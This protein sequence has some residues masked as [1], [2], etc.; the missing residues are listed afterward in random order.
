ML[1]YQ[2]AN[3]LT[4]PATKLSS[5][6]G[7][8]LKTLELYKNKG[9]LDDIVLGVS[10][11]GN[12]VVK[13]SPFK[14]SGITQPTKARSL[15]VFDRQIQERGGIKQAVDYF[16]EGVSIKDLQKFNREMGYKTPVK[17]IAA[18][19]S[20]VKQATGQDQKIPR[21]FIF[22]KKIGAY[23]LNLTGNSKYTTIDVWESRFI[24][25]YFNG[26]FEKNTGLPATVDEDTL[27][28]D[29]SRVF[30]E[31]FDKIAGYDVDPS[32]LQA[33]R[34]F[35]MINAAK[36]A[37]YR[38]ASTNETISEL[39]A[40]KIGA[41]RAGGQA[42]RRAG[43][44]TSAQ[45]RTGAIPEISQD[46]I[47]LSL[48]RLDGVPESF[49]VDGQAVEF[50]YFEPAVEAAK[51]YTA[52]RGMNY[53]PLTEYAPV[54][55]DVARR[56]AAEFELMRHAPDDPEV[57]ASYNAMINETK[58]QYRDILDTGLEVQFIKDED[59]YGN[60]RNAILDVVN[61][62]HL[63]VFPTVDG[64]GSNA[65][66]DVS[67]NPLLQVTEF[68]TADGDPMLAND[69]F[70][71]VHDYFGHIKNGVGFRA[72]GEENAWQAHAAMYSPLARRAMT[73]ET[74]GQNSYVNF[75]PS[76]DFNLTANGADTIYADQKVGLLPLWVSEEARLSDPRRRDP[77]IFQE[78][79]QGAIRDDGKLSLTHFG[80]Q[81]IDR[82][83]PA[84]AGRG[85]DRSRRYS[86]LI[87]LP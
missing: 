77:R 27:F 39:T 86:L 25:S 69:V 85:L 4:S 49:D 26:L 62:N 51:K 24:R 80:R 40:K 42:R 12:T 52:R 61:N 60:P 57:I 79:L 28:Q 21:M 3:G 34:W 15:K 45:A 33:M 75:G 59:P 81:E 20:L 29:F 63:W 74:R 41:T 14:L 58:E 37:G 65:D 9:N 64:F 10:E 55:Q 8:A 44:A 36:Q 43:D 87:R 73:T 17:D 53:E 78:G 18:I 38:G 56:I 68:K 7:D 50:G 11:E 35:Y 72:R 67:D 19:K 66:L 6:V 22:G 16:S 48:K 54:N 2:V 23:T 84:M 46:E 47:S 76:R 70:R 30:K 1:F 71:V 31:E 83:D 5:N 82:T 13:S 32:T